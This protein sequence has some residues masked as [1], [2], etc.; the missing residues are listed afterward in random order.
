M[1]LVYSGDGP[2]FKTVCGEAVLFSGLFDGVAGTGRVGLSQRE[3][4]SARGIAAAADAASR[5]PG[6]FGDIPRV[7]E[8]LRE[9]VTSQDAGNHHGQ[10][11]EAEMTQLAPDLMISSNRP[12]PTRK[13][14]KKGVKMQVVIIDRWEN[15][16]FK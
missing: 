15:F 10:L 16:Y 1:I 3:R 13:T 9:G 2:T 5:Y 8:E 12:P 11:S 6:V 14:N 4:Q 7:E